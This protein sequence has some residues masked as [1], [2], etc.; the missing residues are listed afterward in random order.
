MIWLLDVI[1][2]RE[3]GTSSESSWS[4]TKKMKNRKINQ[5]VG[6]TFNPQLYS[7]ECKGKL[8]EFS[9]YVNEQENYDYWCLLFRVRCFFFFFLFFFIFFC[10]LSFSV[11]Y[12]VRGIV[13]FSSFLIN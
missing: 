6:S 8:S 12:T 7:P 2:R 13:F 1:G 9:V 11:V 4:P 3:Q 10:A 5:F